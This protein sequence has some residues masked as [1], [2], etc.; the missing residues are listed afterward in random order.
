[1]ELL[2]GREQRG[3]VPP[4]QQPQCLAL[5][6]TQQYPLELGDDLSCAVLGCGASSLSSLVALESQL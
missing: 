5:S 2:D 4:Q 3:L 1:M 6:K